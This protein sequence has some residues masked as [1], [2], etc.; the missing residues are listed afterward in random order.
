MPAEIPES[1]RRQV[2]AEEGKRTGKA[3]GLKAAMN[4]SPEDRR[5]RA[6]KAAKTRWANKNRI[7]APVP[8]AAKVVIEPCPNCGRLLR[9]SGGVY[10][11][12]SAGGCGK[13]YRM[14]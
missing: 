1:I 11:C 7:V 10:A 8:V 6:R 14:K 4:M 9:E 5:K 2:L 13:Q 12:D 3:G